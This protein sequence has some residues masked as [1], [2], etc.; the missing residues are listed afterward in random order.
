MAAFA[1]RRAF[2]RLTVVLIGAAVLTSTSGC[3]AEARARRGLKKVV[4]KEIKQWN[5]YYQREVKPNAYHSGGRFYRVFKERVN[6]TVTMRRTNSVDT[7]YMA[8]I[9]FTESRYVTR[10]R[11]TAEEAKKDV[12]F[13][14]SNTRKGEVIYTFVAGS[15]KKKEVY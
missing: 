1:G 5:K 12:H 8:T 4:H 3:S 11:A 14:L 2:I 10:R 15:W 9:S 6:P 7:P 13:I